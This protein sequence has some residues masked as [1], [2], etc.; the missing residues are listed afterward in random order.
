[1]DGEK[2]R[3][4][5]TRIFDALADGNGLPMFDAMHPDANYTIYGSTK[6]SRTY[7]GRKDILDN[8]FTPFGGE[9][10]G[11]IKLVAKRIMVDGET[12]VVEAVSDNKTRDGQDY[13]NRHCIIYRFEDGQ[14]VDI[15]NYLDTE[16]VTR[17]FGE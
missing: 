17:V 11:P 9:L 8:I 12:V 2:L 6:W 13:D 14:I 10:D 5:M 3:T 15:V 7:E 4:L 1:M 16:L